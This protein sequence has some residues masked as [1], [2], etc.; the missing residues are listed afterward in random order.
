MPAGAGRSRCRVLGRVKIE[1]S[2]AIASNT[3]R[4]VVRPES[5]DKAPAAAAPIAKNICPHRRAATPLPIVDDDIPPARHRRTPVGREALAL[6]RS[7]AMRL[8]SQLDRDLSVPRSLTTVRAR[9]TLQA[10]LSRPNSAEAH[11]EFVARCRYRFRQCAGQCDRYRSR[12][13]RYHC[14]RRRMRFR[15]KRTVR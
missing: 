10:I 2:E 3:A 12:S 8:T 1:G 6:S 13:S 15:G 4:E 9:G 7:R 14:S 11:Y 5:D